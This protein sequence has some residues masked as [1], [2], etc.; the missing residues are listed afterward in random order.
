M[1]FVG[2]DTK[3]KTRQHWPIHFRG[4]KNRPKKYYA[5]IHENLKKVVLPIQFNCIKFYLYRTFQNVHHSKAA[6]AEENKKN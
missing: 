4:V 1:D 2:L 6:F 3:Y 5:G